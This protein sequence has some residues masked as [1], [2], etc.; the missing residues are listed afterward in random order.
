MPD[1]LTE[2]ERAAI[3]AFPSERIRRFKPGVTSAAYNFVWK[4][5]SAKGGGRLVHSDPDVRLS[6]RTGAHRL[7]AARANK[8][9][10][11]A[12]A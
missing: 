3:A 4:E 9:K 2:E 12:G 6:C 8:A 7:A 11:E 5:R 1:I 10:R